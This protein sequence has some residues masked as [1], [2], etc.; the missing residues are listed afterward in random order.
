LI[1]VWLR[2]KIKLSMTQ[3]LIFNENIK[4][5]NLSRI[6]KLNSAFYLTKFRQY[7]KISLILL[8]IMN[9]QPSSQDSSTSILF[10]KLLFLNYLLCFSGPTVL[11]ACF[12]KKKKVLNYHH[13]KIKQIISSF[14]YT[15]FHLILKCDH[16]RRALIKMTANVI[17]YHNGHFSEFR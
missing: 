8:L 9:I 13:R 15:V 6:K 3:H 7:Y 1:L 10:L 4:S 16:D 12:N 17:F 5:L 2:T 11:A 14:L